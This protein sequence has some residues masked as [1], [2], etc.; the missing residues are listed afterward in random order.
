MSKTVFFG[1]RSRPS[2]PY[3]EGGCAPTENDVFA[4][5]VERGL[6]WLLP[7]GLLGA[8]TSRTGFFLPSFQEWR[9]EVLL[10]E[11]RPTVVAD[12]SYGVLD[13]AIVE[14]APYYLEKAR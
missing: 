12:L 14:T 6:E 1:L 5:F 7:Q 4:A 2:N 10:G 8:I 3:V 13:T 9:E 11:A